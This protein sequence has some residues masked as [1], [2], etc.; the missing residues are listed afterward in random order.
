M[1][2]GDIV[3][4]SGYFSLNLSANSVMRGRLDARRTL[5]SLVADLRLKSNEPESITSFGEVKKLYLNDKKKVAIIVIQTWY[6]FL[7]KQTDSICFGEE[8]T[9]NLPFRIPMMEEILGVRG[10]IYFKTRPK[11]RPYTK[12]YSKGDDKIHFTF[13]DGHPRNEPL[14]SIYYVCYKN[15]AFYK[16]DGTKTKEIK[17]CL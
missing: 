6:R 3:G 9:I 16:A 14:N 5:K 12:V 7:P 2:Q 4:R 10:Q 11:A 13:T 15:G 8:W 1:G 17:I